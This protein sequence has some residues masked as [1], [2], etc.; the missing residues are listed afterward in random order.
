MTVAK[1]TA[2]LGDNLTP[3][4]R[5]KGMPHMTRIIL[6]DSDDI[7]PTGLFIGHNGRTFMIRSGVEVDVPDELLEVLDN[8]LGKVAVIDPHTKRVIDHRNKLRFPYQIVRRSREARDA[9]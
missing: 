8:A 3:E 5:T 6:N 7:P 2:E 9:A 4:T 1:A